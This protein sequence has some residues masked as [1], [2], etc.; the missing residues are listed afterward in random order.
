MRNAMLRALIGAAAVLFAAAGVV[1]AQA[2]GGSSLTGTAAGT[3][4]GAMTIS[5]GVR[6][7]KL[8]AT[9]AGLSGN[10]AGQSAG[11][12]NCTFNGTTTADSTLVAE[13]GDGTGSCT[14]GSIVVGTI[15]ITCTITWKRVGPIELV[16]VS[17]TFTTAGAMWTG[18]GAGTFLWTPTD[19][20]V[21]S[22]QLTGTAAQ[23]G[24]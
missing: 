15:S 3:Y 9:L 4:T 20:G 10:T 8:N 18:S 24:S 5:P 12:V 19:S 6:S 11:T 1:P 16:T 13:D 21:N 23:G 17:C 7:V 22:F 14:G 2:A